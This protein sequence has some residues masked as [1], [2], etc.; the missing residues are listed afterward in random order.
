MNWNDAKGVLTISEAEGTYPEAPA[1]RK[2]T[3]RKG[4]K[5]KTINYKG[6]KTTVKI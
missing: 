3:V 5:T 1:T 6:K 2:M 4:G